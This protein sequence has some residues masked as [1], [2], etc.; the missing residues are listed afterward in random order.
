[1]GLWGQINSVLAIKFSTREIA[2]V[3]SHRPEST[4]KALS[5]VVALAAAAIAPRLVEADSQLENG[6]GERFATSFPSPSEKSQDR[7]ANQ[8]VGARRL[9]ERYDGALFQLGLLG[10]TAEGLPRLTRRGFD[11]A[12]LEN[13]VLDAGPLEKARWLSD[14]EERFYIQEVVANTAVEANPMRWILAAIP[15]GIVD[16]SRMIDDLAKAKPEWSPS[17]VETYRVGATSRSVQLRVLRLTASGRKVTY[18]LG[19]NAD[20]A[21]QVLRNQYATN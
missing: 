2:R 16:R 11:F 17:Q 14:Q 12:N 15:S 10:I 19:P 6:R 3:L 7:F 13:P 5:G 8:Y 4:L 20:L 9:D 18:Q 21:R 1:V